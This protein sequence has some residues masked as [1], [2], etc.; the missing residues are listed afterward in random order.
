[1]AKMSKELEEIME[2]LTKSEVVL[3]QLNV[4]MNKALEQCLEEFI[5]KKFVET[6]IESDE[7]DLLFE[8]VNFIKNE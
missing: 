2:E 5:V 3:Q 8:F 1:M 4:F 7:I 6:A